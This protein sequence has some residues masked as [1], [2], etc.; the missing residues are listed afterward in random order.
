VPTAS[1]DHGSLIE[2]MIGHRL[3]RS[4]ST[5]QVVRDGE[6]RLVVRGLK[7]ATLDGVDLAVRP[8][9]VVGVAGITGSGREALV[10]FVT[11]QAPSDAGDVIVNGVALPNYDPAA[12]I[13]AGL[14]F[15]PADRAANGVVP[16]AS[17]VEN[18][19]LADVARHWRGGRLRHGEEVAECLEWIAELSIKAPS[20][21][22]PLA[23]LSGGNQQKVLFGRGLRL[24]PTVLVLDEPTSGIDVAAKDQILMLIAR[25]AKGGAA[26]LV[27]STD[28]DE[29]VQVSDRIVVMSGGRIVDELS[30]DEMT[31]EHVEH[32]QLMTTKAAER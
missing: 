3:E 23:T 16:F 30:G 7:G 14:A 31:P 26:V 10:P 2:L 1:L 13:R 32:A 17:V 24:D 12:A 18:L 8:G 20:P 6:P 25:A 15:V 19:T 27:A 28:T 11:G 22:A 4:A 29:L 9:E 21:A 5:S